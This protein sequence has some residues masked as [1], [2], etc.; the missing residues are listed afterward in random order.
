MLALFAGATLYAAQLSSDARSA[1]PS[2][3][4]QLVVIDYRQMQNSPSAVQLRDQVMPPE[5]KRFSEALRK[6]GLDDNHNVDELA[7]ATF[8]LNIRGRFFSRYMF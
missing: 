2:D 5:L 7:F 4:R 1:I 6:S 3:L 8:R